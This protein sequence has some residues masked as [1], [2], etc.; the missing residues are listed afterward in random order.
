MLET[1]R[2]E[3]KI[4]SATGISTWLQI[5]PKDLI[6]KKSIGEGSFGQVYEGSWLGYRVAIKDIPIDARDLFDTETKVLAKLESPFIVQMIGT[7]IEGSH[8]YIVMELVGSSLDKL[9]RNSGD[10]AT[11][12][13]PVAVDMMLQISRGM[14]YLHRHGI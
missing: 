14:E 1:I 2:N 3:C 6:K 13:L 11:L 8:C 10:R 4:K 9:L 5:P 12:A 7:C